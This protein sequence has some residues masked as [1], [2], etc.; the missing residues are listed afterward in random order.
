MPSRARSRWIIGAALCGVCV[1]LGLWVVGVIVRGR[2]R[3]DPVVWMAP[4][5]LEDGSRLRMAK[6]LIASHALARRT[7]AEVI[8]LLGPTSSEERPRWDMTYYL[9]AEDAFM[10]FDSAWLVLAL[11]DDGR[12]EN[13]AVISD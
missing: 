9:G 13:A 8:T 10:R 5:S 3:F 11:D 6:Y 12:V 2:D 7:R 4:Q 1:S